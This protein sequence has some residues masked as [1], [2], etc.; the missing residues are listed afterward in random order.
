M[1]DGCDLDVSVE[2]IGAK[3]GQNP[4]KKRVGV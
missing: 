1:A 2:E 3:K 4:V